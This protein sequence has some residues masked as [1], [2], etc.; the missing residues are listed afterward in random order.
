MP[1]EKQIEAAAVSDARFDGWKDFHTLSRAQRE[2]YLAR[3]KLAL[4]A[5][6]AAGI[7]TVSI[8]RLDGQPLKFTTGEDKQ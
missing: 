7:I 3:S 1:T 2:R 8:R 5:A 6:E 4:E